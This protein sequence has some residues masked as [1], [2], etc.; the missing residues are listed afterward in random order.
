[1]RITQA[2]KLA[3]LLMVPTFAVGQ[4]GPI[5]NSQWDG[6]VSGAV[7]VTSYGGDY[8]NT[9]NGPGI[10]T[11]GPSGEARASVAYT[12]KSGF[13]AQLDNVYT[14]DV[15]Y[16]S[17]GAN[18]NSTRTGASALDVAAH[19][20]YRTDK[21]LAGVYGQRTSFS[22]TYSGNGYTGG[23]SPA[24]AYFLGGEG[25]YYFDR[26]TIYGQAGYQKYGFTNTWT[27]AGY[28]DS[29]ESPSGYTAS[30]TGRYF[31]TDNWKIDGGYAYGRTTNSYKWTDA[32]IDFS[33][34][35]NL[36]TIGTEY[37]LDGSPVSFFGKYSYS[38]SANSSSSTYYDSSSRNFNSNALLVGVKFTFG[39][40]SLIQQDRRGAT[41]NP[42]N[43][44]INSQYNND[45]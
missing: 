2:A 8:T 13:G 10:K 33:Q 29:N 35:S 36:V 21:Y 17:G 45:G 18:G 9:A 20:F 40:G 28:Y 25:Q 5:Q 16:G 12:D 11:I 3:A 22:N 24:R 43:S 34:N 32:R 4:T 27:G 19:F 26:A 37:R 42:V 38:S 30:L 39:T 7:G 14:E 41:L 23:Y 44:R 31:I 1:M 6:Y 15:T